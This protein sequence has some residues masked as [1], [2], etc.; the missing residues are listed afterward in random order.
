MAAGPLEWARFRGPN[1]SGIS[2]A[3]NVP[4]EFGPAKNLALEAA[5]AVGALVADSS[6]AIGSISRRFAET[7][8][9]RSRSI[10][11]RAQMLWEREAP[12]E[13]RNVVDK[14]NNPASP[15]PAVEA[16]GVYVFFPD[17]GLL[18]YDADGRERWTMPLGPFNNIYGMGASP[19]IVGDLLVLAC[20]Q[21]TGSFLLAL[22]KRTGRERWR[23]P[24][25]EAKSG[26][27]TP[28]VWRA[29][30][31]QRPD[32]A[33]GIVPAHGVRARRPAGSSGGCAGC[34][35]RSSRRR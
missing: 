34:R 25:P 15:S 29:P 30:N 22:D 3:A 6:G 18:A 1:G 4:I 17:Y 23:T 24:R 28:I 2:A 13:T 33:A 20:D 14:R 35:S 8:C 32:P 26:H 19:V 9:S 11:T 10:G 21:S 31:G 27:A 12:A 16:D 5:A 7:G